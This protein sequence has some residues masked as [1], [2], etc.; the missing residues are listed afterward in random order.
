L[1]AIERNVLGTDASPSSPTTMFHLP[2]V[3][4]APPAP[5]DQL[6]AHMLI[7]GFAVYALPRVANASSIR[8][9]PDAQRRIRDAMRDYSGGALLTY[10]VDVQDDALAVAAKAARA[11]HMIRVT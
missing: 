5:V 9:V 7:H 6:T 10:P 2:H 3:L 11:A 8:R 1:E 4:E